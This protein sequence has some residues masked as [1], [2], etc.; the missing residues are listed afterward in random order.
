LRFGFSSL[1]LVAALATTG[2]A[3]AQTAPTPVPLQKK[4]D[5]SPIA[6]MVGTWSCTQKSSRR[7]QPVTWKQTNAISKDGYWLVETSYSAGVP[8]YPHATNTVDRVTYDPDIDKWVDLQYDDNGNYNISSAPAPK[9]GT[10]DWKSVSL[11]PSKEIASF[12]DF[13][14]TKDSATKV[15]FHNSFK[16]TKG[17]NVT[18]TGSCT[19]T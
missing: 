5:F 7:P 8:W 19:K 9:N 6:F 1:A 14:F 10:W 3:S 4:P 2:I 13:Y 16:T 15:S 18:V 12:T 11:A 17:Q